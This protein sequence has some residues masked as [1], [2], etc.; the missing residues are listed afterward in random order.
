MSE[1]TILGPIEIELK[2][3]FAHPDGHTASATYSMPVGQPVSAENIETAVREALAAV[4]EK[5]FL[6]MGPDTFFNGVLVKRKFGRVGNFAAPAEFEYSG[7]GLP[8]QEAP[9]TSHVEEDEE[10]DE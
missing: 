1:T 10:G 8:M 7:F 3:H 2:I 6:L 5:G 4:A 9:R